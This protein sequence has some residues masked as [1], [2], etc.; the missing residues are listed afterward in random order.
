MTKRYGLDWITTTDVDEYIWITDPGAMNS[1]D[2]PPVQAFLS[3]FSDK[4][5][6]AALQIAFHLGGIIKWSHKAR[7]LS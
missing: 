1:I 7:S 2:P 5:D 3:Q 6:L 4:P